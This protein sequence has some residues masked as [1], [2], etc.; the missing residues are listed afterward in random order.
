MTLNLDGTTGP[1]HIT[2]TGRELR[3]HGRVLH[4]S[5]EACPS[6]PDNRYGCHCAPRCAC[7]RELDADGGHAGGYGAF[8]G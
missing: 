4:A 3:P 8:C 6:D 5:G 1:L 7:G 2:D